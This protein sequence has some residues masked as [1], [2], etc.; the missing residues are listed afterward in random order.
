MK[1]KLKLT[2][3]VA[4]A[5]LLT[6]GAAMAGTCVKAPDDDG[7]WKPE[8]MNYPH[9]Y[10]KECDHCF[11]TD[12]DRN[13]PGFVVKQIWIEK[14]PK[15]GKVLAEYPSPN[16]LGNGIQYIPNPGFK[17]EDVVEVTF[18]VEINGKPAHPRQAKWKIEVQ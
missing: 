7:Q 18:E 17:G 16:P 6:S 1:A 5:A 11:L 8:Q 4:L 9:H 15:H 2:A 12:S 10:M 3:A 14:D 13:N